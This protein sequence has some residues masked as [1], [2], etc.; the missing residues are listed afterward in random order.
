MPKGSIKKGEDIVRTGGTKTT[1]CTECHG[2]DLRGTDKFPPL[3]GRSPSY[4]VRALYDM[5]SRNR[6][7]IGSVEMEPVLIGLSNEDFLNIAAYLASLEP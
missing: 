3:A 7:G 2:Q 6:G 4:M 5:Q 1:P